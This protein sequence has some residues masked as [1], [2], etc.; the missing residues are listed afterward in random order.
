MDSGRHLARVNAM[1]HGFGP[2]MFAQSAWLIWIDILLG[3]G[4]VEAPA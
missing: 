4:N 2:V 1:V 3:R